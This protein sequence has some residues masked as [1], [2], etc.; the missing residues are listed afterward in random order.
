MCG[1]ISAITK[2]ELTDRRHKWIQVGFMSRV[3]PISFSYSKITQQEI[4]EYIKKGKHLDEEQSDINIPNKQIDVK[5]PYKY[6]DEISFYTDQLAG[7]SELY[8]FRYQRQFQ[9]L[10][11]ASAIQDKRKVVIA[12]DVEKLRP[13]L[14][15]VN[16]EYKM[17]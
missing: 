3:M 8:G 2:Q 17:I 14:E 15:Y 6:A 16:L 12:K 1:L 10:L 9:A 4:M 13:L 7:A 5:L 11:K